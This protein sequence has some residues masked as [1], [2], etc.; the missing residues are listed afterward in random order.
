MNR[1]ETSASLRKT[2]SFP[3]WD[4]NGRLKAGLTFL[5]ANGEVLVSKD[6]AAPVAAAAD[7]VEVSRGKYHYVASQAETD[8][9][10]DFEAWAIKKASMNMATYTGCTSKIRH[11]LFGIVG[12]DYTMTWVRDDAVSPTTGTLTLSGTDYTFTFKAGTTT[13]T[14]YEALIT[15]STQL[16]V[17]TTGA[18]YTI[19]AGDAFGPVNLVD[20][21]EASI[22]QPIVQPAAIPP[23]AAAIQTAVWAAVLEGS[24]TAG[25]LVRLLVAVACGP[26]SGYEA[27]VEV[28]MNLAGTKTRMTTDVSDD[29][30]DSILVGDLT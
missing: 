8:V 16:E 13:K 28:F 1:N 20:G 18:T 27:L 26:S 9:A 24:Y 21:V 22:V 30:R 10:V 15:A 12:D 25:D 5:T 4:A 23:T 6:G 11:K 14:N 29:G 3:I 17:W 7:V 19:V 2:G